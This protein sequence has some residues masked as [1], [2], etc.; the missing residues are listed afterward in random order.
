MT[1]RNQELVPI[2]KQPF[3]EAFN[4]PVSVAASWP[5]EHGKNC[6]YCD[7]LDLLSFRNERWVVFRL[8]LTHRV[9]I[10]KGFRVRNRDEVETGVWWD[11][12]EEIDRLSDDAHKCLD[13]TTSQL[14][15]SALLVDQDLIDL[16]AE[17]LEYDRSCQTGS[18]SRRAKIDS[19]PAQIFE[20]AN[21]GL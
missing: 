5:V 2:R 3:G 15:Q 18:A 6:R 4:A 17:T 7:S 1:G 19:F 12:G 13:F 10:G 21:V 20:R 8:E 11:S 9:V 16:N 14:L